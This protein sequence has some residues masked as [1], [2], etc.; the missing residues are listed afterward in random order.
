MALGVSI[1]PL[2]TGPAEFGKGAGDSD[3]RDPARDAGCGPGD[4][5]RWR[6]AEAKPKL[7]TPLLL[8]LPPPLVES[9]LPLLLVRAP[10][11]EA[12]ADE[13]PAVLLPGGD[14][15]GCCCCCSCWDM[16][17]AGEMRPA[18]CTEA[19]KPSLLLLEPPPLPE[20]EEEASCC[21]PPKLGLT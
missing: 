21:R 15:L 16:K 20:E 19:R 6:E 13:V 7:S 8:L 1:T 3:L 4:W 14:R 2:R 5:P 9:S 17:R 10:E 18:G 11:G 12:T